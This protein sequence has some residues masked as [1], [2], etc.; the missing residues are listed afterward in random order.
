MDFTPRYWTTHVGSFP[1]TEP[2]AL[3]EWLNDRL[4]VP[5]WPQFPR[6][7]FLESIYVQYG[8]HLPGATVDKVKEKI[9]FD[10]TGNL[11]GAVEAFYE[12]YLAEDVD[13]FALHPDHA[14][15]F[16]ALLETLRRTPP[17]G[18]GWI[19]GQVIGPISFGLTVTDQDL[20]A[21]LYH[22]VLADVLVKN[23]AMNA[24]WQIRQLRDVRPHVILFVDEPYMASFGSAF[25]NLGQTQ[26]VDMMNEVFDAIHAEGAK[27]GVHCCANTDWSVLLQTRV[28]VL[29]LDAFGFLD[30]LALYP[31]EMR[32][33]LDRGG[34]VAWGIVPNNDA[35]LGLSPEAIVERLQA[36][37]QLISEK[38]HA[39]GI[40]IDP[41][42]FAH[43]SLVTPSCG[44]GSTTVPIAERAIE[45]LSQVA[46]ILC[47]LQ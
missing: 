14:A 1:H 47:T 4:D 30:H 2:V 20:R 33:F 10:T 23:S 43:C 27:A 37:F 35:L 11:M 7:T 15:G 5:A 21:V 29:S 22:E 36:G 24:R 6:R 45:V 44:L 26:A 25:I 19:K 31:A 16:Y 46:Q 3:C 28:D 39:R 40:Q 17:A 9:I 13:S 32:A 41:Q 38:A 42:E 34:V 18:N 12:R 8:P